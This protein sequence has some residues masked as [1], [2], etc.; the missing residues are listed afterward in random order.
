MAGDSDRWWNI[1][2][3]QKWQKQIFKVMDD[4]KTQAFLGSLLMVSLFINESWVLG[5]ASDDSNDALYSVLTFVFVCFCLESVVLTV[6]QPAYFLSFFFWMDLVG[7]ISIILDIG[8]ISGSFFKSGSS[9]QASILRATRA[10]KLGARYGRLMRILKLIKFMRLLPCFKEDEEEKPEPTLTAVRKVSKQ[11]NDVLSQRVAGLVMLLVIV[12][13]FLAYEDLTDFSPNA[14]VTA[15]RTLAKD[16]SVTAASMTEMVRKFERFYSSKDSKLQS[17]VVESPYANALVDATYIDTTD[18]RDD[19]L[20]TYELTYT[21][22]TVEYSVS[23][24]M[25]NSVPNQWEA[26]FGILV[27]LIVMFCLV[28][29]SASLQNSVDSLVVMPLENIMTALRNSATVMLKSMKAMGDDDE[30]KDE[31]DDGELETEMLERMV[32]K[33]VRIVSHTYNTDVSVGADDKNV[34]SAT[35]DWLSKTYA[36]GNKKVGSASATSMFDHTAKLAR[37]ASTMASDFAL[38]CPPSQIDSWH[39][40]VLQYDQT[41]LTTVFMYIFTVLDVFEEFKVD[42]DVMRSFLTELT[43]KYLDNTYHNYYHGFDVAH[44]TYRILNVSSLHLAFSHLEVFSLIVAA[45]GHDVGHLGVN[46]A[47]LVKAKN[48]LALAH[49]DRSPLE[50]MHC[51]V[52]YKILS[53]DSSNIFKGLSEPEW[54]EARKIILSTVLGTD[55][56]HH[57]E[58]I[59]KTNVFLEAYGDDTSKFCSGEKDGIDALQEEKDR[60]FLM[61]ICL[62]CAD[63]SNPYKPFHIC[64]AWAN[65]VSEEF[66]RQGDRE[67]AEGLEVSPM[68]DRATIQLCNMQM[69]FVEFVVA[70][71]IITFIKILPP[72]HEIGTFMSDNYKG[73]AEKRKVEVREDPSITNKDEEIGKLDSRIAAFTGKFEFLEDLRSR[74]SRGGDDSIDAK[75]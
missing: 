26:L 17:L 4:G 70:P 65:R 58:Q 45:V 50:N 52:I 40:D 43:S 20:V 19:N 47:Y 75:I 7:T 39:F 44:T 18:I 9:N 22:S 16:S 12:M 11:L 37:R 21:I 10:A 49:N 61:E 42:Q 72:L 36:Q 3:D 29:F 64:A 15:L 38:P 48:E 59:G 13:P 66:A 41:K 6:V 1:K 14:W 27:I 54:R 69:G 74:K 25:D 73:W 63:I 32:E 5:N 8:W 68:M 46:N 56:A 55:M 60:Y 35:A 57:F 23:A 24:V 2:A 31:D 33:L 28:F 53:N 67:K 34:D 71:L 62:H 51:A 30:A